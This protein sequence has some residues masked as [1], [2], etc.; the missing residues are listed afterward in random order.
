MTEIAS[1]LYQCGSAELTDEIARVKPYLIVD[2]EGSIDPQGEGVGSYLHWGI[3]DGPLPDTYM[4]H[5]V[6]KLV[7]ACS[8]S[9]GGWSVLV[10]CAAGY[11]GASL[12]IGAVLVERG[13]RGR[14]AVALIGAKRLGALTSAQFASCL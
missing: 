5:A 11:N 2:L 4:L 6:A 3:E 14:D 13:M 1:G 9:P 12:V 10:H 8:R 7:Y